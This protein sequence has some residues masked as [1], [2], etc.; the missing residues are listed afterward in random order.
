VISTHPDNEIEYRHKSANSV[1]I[2]SKH[3]VAEPDIVKR[4]DMAGGD[5]CEGRLRVEGQIANVGEGQETYLL[6]QVDIL[7][8]FQSEREVTEKHMYTKK[9]NYAEVAEHTV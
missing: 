2:T 5:A 8:D 4:R 3:D 6:I 9:T 1:G 7:H